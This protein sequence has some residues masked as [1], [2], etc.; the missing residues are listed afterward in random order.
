[1][2]LKIGGVRV[3]S[4]H[5]VVILEQPTCGC[6]CKVNIENTMSLN[7][8]DKILSIEMVKRCDKHNG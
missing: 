3:F 7:R 1:M 8:Q 4:K 2:V 5:D 6:R